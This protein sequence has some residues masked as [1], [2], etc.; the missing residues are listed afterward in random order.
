[1]KNVG[2]SLRIPS[3]QGKSRNFE[4]ISDHERVYA[5]IIFERT[6]HPSK[7]SL[8]ILDIRETLDLYG[9]IVDASPDCVAL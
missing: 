7:I 6:I 5:H 1:M 8:L 2:E 9:N 4:R 3:F